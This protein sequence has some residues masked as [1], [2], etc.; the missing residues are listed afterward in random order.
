MGEFTCISMGDLLKS[1]ANNVTSKLVEVMA[2]CFFVPYIQ[3]RTRVVGSSSTLIDNI[4]VN[5]IEFVTVSSNLLRQLADHLLQFSVFKD[6][7]VSYRPKHEQI[8]KCN[9]TFFNN[10][11]FKTKLIK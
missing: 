9:Y 8:F 2:F 6:F 5:S 11:E 7:R 1:H 10:N 4:F 3:Q